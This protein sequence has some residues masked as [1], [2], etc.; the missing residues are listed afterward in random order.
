MQYII[1]KFVFLV[2]QPDPFVG[3]VVHRRSNSQEMLEKLER[4]ILI[5]RIGERKFQCNRHH[6]QAEHSHPTGTIT[7]LDRAAGGQ[8]SAAIRDTYV[9]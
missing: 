2:P 4:N 8:R 7:L 9:V 5:H 6:V 1:E 3:Y